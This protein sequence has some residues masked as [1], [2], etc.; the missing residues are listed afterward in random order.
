MEVT[1]NNDGRLVIPVSICDRLGL[2]PG[3]SLELEVNTSSTPEEAGGSIILRS[4][5]QESP[6]RRMGDL[7]VHTGRLQDEHFDVVEQL[8]GQR[9]ER[10]RSQ[11]GF[12][13]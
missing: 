8:R 7:L 12:P 3:T 1:V 10:A 11:A 2:K 5:G 9:D 4:K 13:E 6:V